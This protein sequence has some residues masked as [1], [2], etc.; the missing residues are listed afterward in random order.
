[1]PDFNSRWAG[2][3]RRVNSFFSGPNTE[4]EFTPRTHGPGLLRYDAAFKQKTFKAP[5]LL[6]DEII[7]VE[8]VQA[9]FLSP[10]D[11]K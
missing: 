8:I 1:V 7:Q 2:S 6:I 10:V 3:A 11:P 5:T 4:K 9:G